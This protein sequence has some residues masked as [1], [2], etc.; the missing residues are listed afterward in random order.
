MSI[1]DVSSLDFEQE[2][3]I[4]AVKAL[5]RSVGAPPGVVGAAAAVLTDAESKVPNN[6]EGIS[7]GST[8]SVVG[9]LL[10]VESSCKSFIQELD[11]VV[12]S[13]DEITSAHHSVTG[14]TNSLMR[15]CEDLLDR[16]VMCMLMPD[17]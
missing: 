5:T 12:A 6:F 14:R 13:L 15:N 10:D 9:K 11:A 8:S 4:K 7:G 16:Q 2:E 17:Q 3:C 1:W